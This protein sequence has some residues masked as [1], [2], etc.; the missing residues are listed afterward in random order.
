MKLFTI[1]NKVQYRINSFPKE[2]ICLFSIK[3]LI[4]WYNRRRTSLKTSSAEF[5]E[6]KT[7]ILTTKR[8]SVNSFR[9]LLHYFIGLSYGVNWL[10]CVRV[11]NLLPYHALE[12][13]KQTYGW[14]ERFAFTLSTF[15]HTWHCLTILAQQNYQFFFIKKY[16][17]SDVS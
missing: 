6:N 14:N 9:G 8:S 1:V 7:F 4:G 16:L 15:R 2:K 13:Y 17:Y 12:I 11:K 10:T 3:Q 5:R